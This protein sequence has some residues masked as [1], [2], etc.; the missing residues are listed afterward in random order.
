VVGKKNHEQIFRPTELAEHM[1]LVVGSE[2]PEIG[3]SVAELEAM[4]TR[5]QV[6]L[7]LGTGA[8]K[9]AAGLR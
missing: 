3:S 9:L 2:Q 8:R 1:V 7:E 6:A 5:G 4:K